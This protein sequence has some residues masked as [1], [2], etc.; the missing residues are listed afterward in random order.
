[1]KQMNK[2]IHK[3]I[4][5][6]SLKNK[7]LLT[8]ICKKKDKLVRSFFIEKK[9]FFKNFSFYLEDFIDKFVIKHY[10]FQKSLFDKN[11]VI[12]NSKFMRYC[13]RYP[14]FCIYIIKYLK[15]FL[16]YIETY[17]EKILVQR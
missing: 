2:R 6:N 11:K 10:L 14:Y 7:L 9:A 8:K 17:T 15:E 5:I 4:F 12:L 13:F 3:L 1:M 16:L